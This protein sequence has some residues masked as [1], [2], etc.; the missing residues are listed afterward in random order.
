M[1]TETLHRPPAFIDQ[2]GDEAEMD[3]LGFWDWGTY[4]GEWS[5]TSA[6]LADMPL[7]EGVFVEEMV[8][9]MTSVPP[10]VTNAKEAVAAGHVEP[11]VL[12]AP[13]QTK[14][15]YVM[16]PVQGHPFDVNPNFVAHIERGMPGGTWHITTKPIGKMKERKKVPG[17]HA[18]VLVYVIDGE[19]RALIAPGVQEAADAS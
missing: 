10:V 13:I 6:W 17:G 2:P 18:A 9:E 12:L 3:R 15:G 19:A 14:G 5:G 16:L 4:R 8:K 11:V 1:S 7:P